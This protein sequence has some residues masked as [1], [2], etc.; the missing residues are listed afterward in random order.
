MDG[1]HGAPSGRHRPAED[2]L[3]SLTKI[4]TTTFPFDNT[5]IWSTITET[6][7]VKM[8][9]GTNLNLNR[10]PIPRM[11]QMYMLLFLL[12]FL[13]VRLFVAGLKS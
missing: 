11:H 2:L 1:L 10:Y 13:L 4:K 12:P 7:L 6:V 5:F 9:A 3:S 8:A